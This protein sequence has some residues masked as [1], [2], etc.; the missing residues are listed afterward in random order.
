[1]QRTCLIVH[2][3]H[4]EQVLKTNAHNYD[5]RAW[6]YKQLKLLVGDG[7]IT[8]DGKAWQHQRRT[9]QPAF[10]HQR[11]FERADLIADAAE[12]MAARWLEH[13]TRGCPLDVHREMMA[14]T[15]QVVGQL[16]LGVDLT[17][18]T[19]AVADALH[20]ALEE[21]THRNYAMMPWPLSIPT[22]HNRRLRGA[23][24]TIDDVIRMIIEQRGRRVGEQGDLLAMLMAESAAGL[25]RKQHEVELRQQIMTIILTGHESTANA[26]TWT[27]YLLST[28]PEVARTL[29]GELARVLGGRSPTVSDLQRLPYCHMVFREA[30]RLYPPVWFMQRRAMADDRIG[31]YHI[32]AGSIL[33]LSP[34]VTHRHPDFWAQP[35]A[36]DPEHFQP[37]A[38]AQRPRLAYFP[39]GG[40]ARSCIGAGL[41]T[42][43]STLILATLA[44]RFELAPVSTHPVVPQA[45]VT[46]RPRDG[47]KMIVYQTRQHGGADGSICSASA[48]THSQAAMAGDGP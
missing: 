28:H 18:E 32:P 27:W 36:F 25:G 47:M 14:L 17:R 24:R 19:G 37:Q 15:L 11:L 42:L 12:V 46:L 43:E 2:P 41:A 1:M 8:S 23:I 10:A 6:G 40:G 48:S 45:S 26:L 22:P 34:F 30:M 35:E 38:M 31:G 5:K 4:I 20:I 13:A 21:I 39:F 44:Q 29:R 7:L 9:A 3:D 33:F 16:V